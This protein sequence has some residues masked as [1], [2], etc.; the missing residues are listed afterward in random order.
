MAQSLPLIAQL[1]AALTAFTVEADNEAERLVEHHTT[2]D[3]GAR[4]AVWLTSLAMWFNCL[5]DLSDEPLT[6]AELERRARMS[7]NLDGMRRWGYIAIDGTGRVARG[8]TRPKAKRSSRLALTER[9]RRAAQLWAPLPQEIERRWDD[10]F[11]AAAVKELRAA[12]IAVALQSPDALPDF[13]PIGSVYGIGIADPGPRVDGEDLTTR[14]LISLLARVLLAL[15]LDYERD[16][17]LALTVHLNGL[18]VL[19][20][21]AGAAADLDPATEPD[22]AAV[23]VAD[24]P[25]RTGVAK[26]ATTMIVARLER[27]GCAVTEPIPGARRGQQVRLTERGDRAKAAGESRLERV[28]QRAGA[29][30]LAAALTPVVGDGTRAGSP[31]YTGLHSDGWRAR[32]P[33]PDRLPWFPMVL[34]RGGYP[35]GS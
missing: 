17:K 13:L 31:L 5:R 25:A 30:E 33:Q 15:A 28:Q 8:A 34:H 22:P 21:D 1:S 3:G 27:T 35:D 19:G 24:L 4:R 12:L 32:T 18:R 26:A 10:R 14:P 7:T 20:A 11:G 23:P 2:D 29:P 16:A 9:G 6:V